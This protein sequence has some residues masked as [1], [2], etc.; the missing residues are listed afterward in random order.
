MIDFNKTKYHNITNSK[1]IY[2]KHI[3]ISIIFH[4]V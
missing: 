2:K 1:M 4:V 3:E